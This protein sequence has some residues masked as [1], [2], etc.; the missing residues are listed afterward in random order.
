MVHDQKVLSFITNRVQML[1]KMVSK[2]PLGLVD[3]VEATSRAAEAV[4]QV[5]RCT[6]EPLSNVEA[7]FCALNGFERLDIEY[8]FCRL[9]TYL[10]NHESNPPSTDPFSRLQHTHSSWTPPHGLLPFLDLFI[11]TCCREIDHLNHSST[12]TPSN[13]SPTEH[14]ALCSNSNF[15]IKPANKGSTVVTKGVAMG[16]SYACLFTGYVE[17]SLFRCYTGTIPYLFLR[18]IMTV[19]ALL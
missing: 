9:R 14:A 8:F 18:Y 7:L 4:D 13:F 19:L 15:T 10:F 17:L 12:L 11:S 6:R 2:P 1:Y 3:V 16:P 5:D